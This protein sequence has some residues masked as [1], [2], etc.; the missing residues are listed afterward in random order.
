M[1]S[2]LLGDVEGEESRKRKKD[3]DVNDRLREKGVRIL[4]IFGVVVA[5]ESPFRD[6][7]GGGAAP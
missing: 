2:V 6:A 1:E 3:E 4:I 7:A 5:L